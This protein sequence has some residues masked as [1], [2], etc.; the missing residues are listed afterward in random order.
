M[1]FL[2]WLVFTALLA[3][4][5]EGPQF[6]VASVKRIGSALQSPSPIVT[7]S[8]RFSGR[9]A[10]A[11]LLTRA[12]QMPTFLFVNLDKVSND[13]FDVTGTLPAGATQNEIPAMLRNLLI[14]RFHLRYHREMRDVKRFEIRAA[15]NGHKLR[16]SANIVDDHPSF[17]VKPGADGFAEFP[18][19]RDVGPVGFGGRWAMQR[20][21]I[22]VTDFGRELQG[23]WLDGVV[24]DL[25]GLTGKYDIVLKW[26]ASLR[27]TPVEETNVPEFSEPP[28]LVALRDQL[29]LVVRQTRGPAEVIVI[30]NIDADVVPN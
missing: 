16:E 18:A 30:E 12:F 20:I 4:N 24:V 13:Y 23:T 17:T 29:G 9:L 1:R 22:T 28:L 2:I 7:S 15:E 10:P 26:G 21:G 19:G 25:T 8:T 6:E 27:A 5:I 14:E 3:Q 11:G